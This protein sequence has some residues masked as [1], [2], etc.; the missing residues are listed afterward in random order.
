MLLDEISVTL[1]NT[2]FDIPSLIFQFTCFFG[3]W[4]ERL[5][6]LEAALASTKLGSLFPLISLVSETSDWVGSSDFS[7]LCVRLEVNFSFFFSDSSDA[8]LVEKMTQ[9]QSKLEEANETVKQEQHKVI[10]YSS[11]CFTNCFRV[12]D[13]GLDC[14]RWRNWALKTTS[15][16]TVY[17]T[18]CGH[19]EMLMRSLRN[20]QNDSFLLLLL[21]CV[22]LASLQRKKRRYCTNISERIGF[23]TLILED[24]HR[25]LLWPLKAIGYHIIR[26]SLLVLFSYY[27]L[28][29]Y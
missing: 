20:S 5:A 14:T 6:R 10:S 4:Q 1:T 16:S 13:Y 25:L 9:I 3:I 21:W 28:G 24:R 22:F 18:L 7:H 27:H 8:E 26:G 29:W 11:H 12:F 2:C 17:C 19:W 23:C 15:T